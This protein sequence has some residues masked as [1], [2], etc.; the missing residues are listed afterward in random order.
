MIIEIEKEKILKAIEKT[1][2]A[3]SSHNRTYLHGSR[4]MVCEEDF[5][6]IVLN[7]R[8][9]FIH[10]VKRCHI[11]LSLDKGNRAGDVEKKFQYFEDEDVIE[12]FNSK[13]KELC[14]EN[15]EQEKRKFHEVLQ[16]V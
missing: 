4:Y 12:C 14:K 15:Y 5:K 8:F 13:F 16:C 11:S 10:R 6:D 9:P 3:W 2:W 7:K 1:T